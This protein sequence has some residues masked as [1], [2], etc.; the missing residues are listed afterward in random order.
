MS[1]S[2]RVSFFLETASTLL[3]LSL[4]TTWD[5]YPCQCRPHISKMS[6]PYSDQYLN[7]SSALVFFITIGLSVS[8]LS[9]YMLAP[10]GTRCGHVWC[11]TNSVVG[12]APRGPSSIALAYFGLCCT[13]DYMTITTITGIQLYRMVVY[14]RNAAFSY[15]LQNYTIP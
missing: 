14:Q 11:P 5:C 8:I 4:N 12:C 15:I 13:H 2:N 6:H 3:W 1:K 9:E 7:V 10:T